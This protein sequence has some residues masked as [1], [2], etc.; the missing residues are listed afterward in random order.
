MMKQRPQTCLSLRQVGSLALA[1][2][3][4][5]TQQDNAYAQ[6]GWSDDV[7]VVLVYGGGQ[8]S[9]TLTPALYAL[10]SIG[11]IVE[12][13]ETLEQLLRVHGLQLDGEAL[14]A[15]YRLN[16]DLDSATVA[17]GMRLRLPL[18]RGDSVSMARER[19][20]SVAITLDVALKVEISKS[21]SALKRLYPRLAARS[22][23]ARGMET[24]LGDLRSI[25]QRTSALVAAI[26]ERSLPLNGDILWQSAM[27]TGVAE[28]IARGL[29][30]DGGREIRDDERVTLS[31]IAANMRGISAN[32]AATKSPGNWPKRY[33]EVRVVVVV[34]NQDGGEEHGLRVYYQAQ[35]FYGKTTSN[36]TFTEVTS[37]TEKALPVANWKIWAGVPGDPSPVTDVLDVEVDVL[38]QEGDSLV[39][40]LVRRQN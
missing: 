32:L 2:A 7:A 30:A 39:V 17:S 19:G 13:G 11:V 24:V 9:V 16:P 5:V 26:R 1:L 10:D 15:V 14:E 38:R 18:I 33:P 6:S 12:E 34:L 23:D 22:W 4:I 27:E 8:S 28:G 36:R 31:S 20:A 21:D 29:E 37:P 25:L 40:E 35:W 3:A